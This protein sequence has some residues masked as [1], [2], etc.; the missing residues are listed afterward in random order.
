MSEQYEQP[1]ATSILEFPCA[2]TVKAVG[3]ATPE[4][5]SAVLEIIKQHANDLLNE[6]SV[7][8]RYSRD[9]NYLA[10]SITIQAQSKAQLDSIYHDL[11]KEP[12]VKM[13]L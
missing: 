6:H 12:L 4:F 10:L 9:K 11:T 8:Q 7:R 2:F 3:K 1:S 13:A 5:E